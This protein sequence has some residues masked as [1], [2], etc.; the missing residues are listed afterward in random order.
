MLAKCNILIASL[1][2]EPDEKSEMFSQMLYGET[3]EILGNE[4]NFLKIKMNFDGSEGFVNKDHLAEIAE[5]PKTFPIEKPFEIFD[6]PEGKNVLSIGA[7]VDFPV[8]KSADKNN[9]RQSISET[10]KKFLNVPFLHGGRS[11]FGIDSAGFVQL[12]FKI[13]GIALPRKAEQQAESGKVLDFL[14]EGE[15]GDLAFFENADGKIFHVG[16]LLNNSELIHVHEKVRIDTLD[17]SGI[18][19]KNLKKHTHKLRFVRRIF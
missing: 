15:A 13:H 12:V 4:G 17:S 6:F 8:E 3:C 7:E 2:S 10:A 9:I 5:I 16:I 1:R 11:F 14:G 19:N 18:F